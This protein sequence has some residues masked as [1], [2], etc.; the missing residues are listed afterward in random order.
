[1]LPDFSYPV[2]AL[3]F[4]CFQILAMLFILFGL[5]APR[6]WLS[7]LCSLVYLL[8]DFGYPV[9][10]LWLEHKQDSQSLGASKPKSIN[11]IA[12][13]WEQVNQRA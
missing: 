4:T 8:P 11:K 9:Y 3:W 1:L 6:L 13:V 2:Y 10:A 12:K 5:L 7:C